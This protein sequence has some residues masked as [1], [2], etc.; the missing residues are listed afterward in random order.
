M[1]V[2]CKPPLDND[3]A[4]KNVRIDKKTPLAK[5]PPKAKN[6]A[7]RK[8]AMVGLSIDL[9]CTSISNTFEI[10]AATKMNQASQGKNI[11]QMLVFQLF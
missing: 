7:N 3:V 9:P 10:M 6:S 11:T 2:S 1:A 5:A 4:T 8:W